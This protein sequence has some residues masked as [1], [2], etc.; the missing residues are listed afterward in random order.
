MVAS[1]TQERAVRSEIEHLFWTHQERVLRAAYRVTGSMA[2]AEDV[3]QSIFLRLLS[4][5]AEGIANVESYLYRAA[6]NGA[7]DL[8]RSRQ[9][10]RNVPIEGVAEPAS[11]SPLASPERALGNRELRA[12][13]RQAIGS[14]SPRSAEM[15]VL[16]YLEDRDHREIA[17]LTGTSR[18]VVAVLL[19]RARARLQKEFRNFMR[20]QR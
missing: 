13:L 6:I 15:F 16:R 18:A 12:W 4:Q 14:L 3:A 17:R 10:E 2:D 9:S 8:V 5:G 1:A 7:L 11:G 19:S 20:G